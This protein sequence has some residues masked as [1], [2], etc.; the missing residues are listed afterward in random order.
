MK[1]TRLKLAAA[2]LM[3]VLCLI[4]VV[5]IFNP[6]V[7]MRN[8]ELRQSVL[9]L[10]AGETVKLNDVVP[11][12][13][14][15]VYTFHPYTSQQEIEG[16]IG[17]SSRAIKETVS[18]GMVQLLFVR[19]KKVVASVCGYASQL[20]YSI[21]LKKWDAPVSYRDDVQC[22]VEESMGVTILRCMED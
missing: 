12:E 16:I 10:E 18:E 2:I 14:D 5:W 7:A 3:L 9:S 21:E 20:G 11:F 1:K 15:A 13:W 6:A 17:F 8:W 19:E 22:Q 4:A